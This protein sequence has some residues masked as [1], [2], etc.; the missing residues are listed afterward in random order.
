MVIFHSY[1]SLPEGNGYVH[2][3][4]YIY[5][6]IY[7]HT[8]GH[9]VYRH[10]WNRHMFLSWYRWGAYQ[11]GQVTS[12]FHG[13]PNGTLRLPR[14]PLWRLHRFQGL[15]FFPS[16][17][18]PNCVGITAGSNGFFWGN[19]GNFL[20]DSPPLS[21]RCADPQTS[22]APLPLVR[23]LNARFSVDEAFSRTK[24]LLP[25][26]PKSGI[27]NPLDLKIFDAIA[28]LDWKLDKSQSLT[29]PGF[30]ISWPPN[31]ASV[32]F[33][34][35][36]SWISGKYRYVQQKTSAFH[37]PPW[38]CNPPA[39]TLRH[40]GCEV[41]LQQA[42]RRLRRRSE[43]GTGWRASRNLQHQMIYEQRIIQIWYI[44]IYST[45]IYILIYILIYIYTYIYT[46]Y[47]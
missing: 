25:V 9:T 30:K 39:K 32:K 8:Y 14:R 31:L 41:F 5:I 20:V 44:Y 40:S 43:N 23:Y 7:I 47:I 26:C 36:Q 2:S 13:I 3:I 28:M 42:H 15:G 21:W 27:W 37:G 10:V 33:W 38:P 24:G 46:Y 11:F 6:Y 16:P 12:G 35:S 4:L 17:E 29:V 34:V 19:G 1:V 45:Y 22:P 18:S